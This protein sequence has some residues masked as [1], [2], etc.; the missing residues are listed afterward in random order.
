MNPNPQA[1]ANGLAAMLV[2]V[3]TRMQGVFDILKPLVD[4]PVIRF[5]YTMA[6]KV[7]LVIPAGMQGAAFVA[8]DFSHSLEWPFEVHEMKPTQDPSHTF[9]NWRLQVEDQTFNQR[10]FKTSTRID[11][12][13]DDNTGL[14]RLVFPW[15]VRPKG[16]ALS[17][18]ADNLDTVNPISVE[19]TFRGFL[20]I[21]RATIIAAGILPAAA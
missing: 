14:Y 6:T 7:P 18:T 17:L 11:G 3:A 10:W 21:P 15:I 8:S 4:Q 2:Q 5:P 12:L 16:G 20:M 1:G 13:V 19:V 9:Q